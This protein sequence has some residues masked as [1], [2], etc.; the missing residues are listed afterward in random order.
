MTVKTNVVI[1]GGANLVG[2]FPDYPTYDAVLDDMQKI[3]FAD[4]Q[5]ESKNGVVRA[6]FNWT[7]I[8]IF[9]EYK[10][11]SAIV[12]ATPPLIRATH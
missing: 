2:Y 9:C 5:I 6:R 12:P 3:G 10:D 8:A 1:T 7:N 4:G 11:E